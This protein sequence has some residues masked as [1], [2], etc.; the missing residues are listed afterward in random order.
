MI[1]KLKIIACPFTFDAKLE[2]EKAPKTCEAFLK[3]MPLSGKIVHVRWS[4]E[5]VDTVGQLR[6]WREL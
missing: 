6:I 3:Q 4:G 1:M 5:G 2:T